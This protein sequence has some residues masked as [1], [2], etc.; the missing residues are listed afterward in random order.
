MHLI[1][2]GSFKFIYLFRDY[3][4]MIEMSRSKT[5]V[6]NYFE[7]VFHR[8]EVYLSD[9][10]SSETSFLIKFQLGITIRV[11]KKKVLDKV[12]RKIIEQ[13]LKRKKKYLYRVRRLIV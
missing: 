5:L 1:N 12:F 10:F 11:K 13:V 4:E 2:Y 9:F 6:H 3:I 8:I 7:I